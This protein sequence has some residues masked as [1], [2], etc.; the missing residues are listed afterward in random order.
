MKKILLITLL[1][2][3]FMAGCATNPVKVY[4]DAGE[5][6][7]ILT[8]DIMLGRS[9]DPLTDKNGVNYPFDDIAKYLKPYPVIFGNLEA[10]FVDEENMPSVKKYKKKSIYLYVDDRMADGF[11][12]AGFNVL[13]LANNHILDY[14]QEG[15]LH[16]M[17]VLEKKK[18]LYGGIV[19]GDLGKPNEPI[20]IESNGVRIGFLC[21]SRVSHKGFK[22][23]PKNYG[24]IPGMYKEIKRDMKNAR[25]KVDILAVYMHWGLEGRE[26]QPKQ[27]SLARGIIGLGADVVFGSHTHL[28]QD[29]EKY[30]G[31][32]IF[33]G[34]GNFI[35]DMKADISRYS[36][37]VTLHIK[38]KKIKSAEVTPLYLTDFRPEVITDKAE[39]DKFFSG[40]KLKNLKKEEIY[41]AQ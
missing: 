6:D 17:Q 13:S 27:V 19:K 38:D 32:Y 41:K 1:P 21:Y 7:V 12:N 28:F 40:V 8:G 10:P 30:K 33:Y 26:V 14:G 31:K 22:A 39:L 20:I 11:L 24:T 3:F 37:F 9:M 36:G 2:V 34:L 18:I 4:K 16:T 25:P 5:A 35:F 23:S 15:L 29:I